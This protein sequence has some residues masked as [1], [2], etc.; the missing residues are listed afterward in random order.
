M[1]KQTKLPI[2]VINGHDFDKYMLKILKTHKWNIEE[3]KRYI[4]PYSDK[5]SVTIIVHT[6]F[7]TQCAQIM[8]TIKLNNYPKRIYWIKHIYKKIITSP[9]PKTS[10]LNF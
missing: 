1:S 3:K 8:Q 5:E 2:H 4:D 7:N 6:F 10:L 9:L